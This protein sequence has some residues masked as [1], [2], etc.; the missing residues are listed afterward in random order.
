MP[1]DTVS[2]EGATGT[3]PVSD[4]RFFATRFLLPVLLALA[5]QFALRMT[6]PHCVEPDDADLILFSQRPALGYSDQ[7]PLYSWL[8]EGL[9]R[10]FGVGVVALTVMRTLVVFAGCVFLWL[11]AR[12]VSADRRLALFG[13]FGVLLVPNL[14]WHALAYLTHSNLLLVACLATLYTFLR[15][16]RGGRAADYAWFGAACAAGVLSKYNFVWFAGSLLAAGLTVGPVRRRLLD[17]RFALTVAVGAVLVLPHAVWVVENLD[18]LRA[19]LKTKVHRDELQGAGYAARVGR[20]LWDAS[21][22]TLLTAGPAAVVVALMFPRPRSNRVAG[23]PA[24]RSEFRR[25]AVTLL[26]RFFVVAAGVVVFQVV[27]LGASRF[28]ERWLMPFAVVLPVWLFA[29]VEPG[30]V[31]PGRARWFARLLVALAVGYTAARAVQVGWFADYYRGWYPIRTSYARLAREIVA[32]V[33]PRPTI[34]APEREVGGNLRLVM[35]ETPVQCPYHALYP[36]PA[37]DGPVVVAWNLN[38]TRGVMTPPWLMIPDLY[39]RHGGEP[40]P[41][42]R[43]RFT[44]VAPAAWGK[45]PA[46]IAWVVFPPLK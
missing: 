12:M 21:V 22:S 33:G 45:P 2:Q 4:R 8:C 14:A 1:H 28:H 5:A 44:E 23:E 17:P 19:I 37:G 7:P 20:G 6:Y 30:W 25:T 34:V 3:G 29:R 10:V 35:P 39:A 46:T 38:L 27:G 36:V 42:E 43:I 41:P 16:V 26:D 32:E 40:I 24:G 9:F 15:V 18:G 11:T 13:A 31:R